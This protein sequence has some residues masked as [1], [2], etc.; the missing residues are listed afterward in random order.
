MRITLVLLLFLTSATALL[1]Q[2]R[3]GLDSEVASLRQAIA[4]AHLKMEA[5]ESEVEHLEQRIRDN[6]ARYKADMDRF[7]QDMARQNERQKDDILHAIEPKLDKLAGST[8]PEKPAP[9]FSNNYPKEG[10]SYTVQAGDTLSGIAQ[11]NG[12]RMDDIKNANKI[13]D[14]SK[15]QVGQTI[16]VP[17]R[18]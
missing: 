3:S 9:V 10:I 14:P 5:L 2:Q 6:E 4:Q 12:A 8:A 16:F 15:L 18:K 7:R 17:L 13:A 11:K 1:A